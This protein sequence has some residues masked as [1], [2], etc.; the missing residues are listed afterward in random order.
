MARAILARLDYFVQEWL[1]PFWQSNIVTGFG[2][3]ARTVLAR[4]AKCHAEWLEPFGNGQ[5]RYLE[6]QNGSPF[7]HGHTVTLLACKS[8]YNS[9]HSGTASCMI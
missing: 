4:P 6:C 7:W 2:R 1:E 5:L 8:G 3:I 9:S